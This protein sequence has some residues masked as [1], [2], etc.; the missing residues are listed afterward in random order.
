MY[1]SEPWTL[2]IWFFHC[3][4]VCFWAM[5]ADNFILSLK[6]CMFLSHALG[7]SMS[8]AQKHTN[9]Q[10]NIG[11]SI[12]MLTFLPRK[13]ILFIC[14]IDCLWKKNNLRFCF[15]FFF[16]WDRMARGASPAPPVR[17]NPKFQKMQVCCISLML[18]YDLYED[19]IQNQRAPPLVVF[20]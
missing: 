5:D 3:K 8:M 12:K 10:W 16:L 1:V 9:S 2:I 6:I 20:N 13:F 7:L 19:V 18:F 17:P 15:F 4:Y 14:F 11:M